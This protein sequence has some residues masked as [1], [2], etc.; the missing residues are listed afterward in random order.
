MPALF[1]ENSK[2]MRPSILLEM[3][4]GIQANLDRQHAAGT[5]INTPNTV[6]RTAPNVS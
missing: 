2:K 4:L 1:M 3:V 5:S 6:A